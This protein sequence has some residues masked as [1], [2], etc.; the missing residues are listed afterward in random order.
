MSTSYCSDM[1]IPLF[2]SMEIL[3]HKDWEETFP[4]LCIP[5]DVAWGG[6]PV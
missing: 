1:K 4:F 3:V 6:P 5:V 2:E